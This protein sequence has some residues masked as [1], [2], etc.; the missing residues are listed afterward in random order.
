MDCEL[1]KPASVV[2]ETAL[3]LALLNEAQRRIQTQEAP[4]G[5]NIDVNIGAGG[6]RCVLRSR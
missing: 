2:A 4:D 1:C 5:Y 6:I 3:V